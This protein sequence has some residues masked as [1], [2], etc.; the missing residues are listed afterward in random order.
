MEILAKKRLISGKK[1]K[2]LRA[3]GLLPAVIYSKDSSTG[4]K[5]VESITVNL[6][7]FLV[8]YKEVGTSSILDVKV[9]GIEKPF[10]TLV[11]KIQKDPVTLNLIHVNFFEVDLTETVTRMVPVELIN[12]DS[13]EP[14][15]NGSGLLITVLNEIEIECLPMDIPSEFKVDVSG[16]QEVGDN[17]TIKDS[18]N[19]DT[20]K[21]EIKTD[22]EEVVVKVD[23]AEQLEVEEEEVS[24]E[25]VE[26]TTEKKTEE[27]EEET[28]DE[29]K[30]EKSTTEE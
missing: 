21:I 5:E 25:D 6:K 23:Y 29:K 24:I 15:Q 4:K 14:V 19:V 16:L 27:G 2:R 30:E 13:C 28:S 20:S 22:S 18:I 12:E 11:S 9:E 7:D 17:L 8:A 10:K 26:V 3:E 1:V